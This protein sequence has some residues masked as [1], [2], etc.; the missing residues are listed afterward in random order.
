[1]VVPHRPP[2]RP[3][4]RHRRGDYCAV[5]AWAEL[6]PDCA[7]SQILLAVAEDGKPF[8]D[9][10]NQLW[11]GTV[12]A[13]DGASG[14]ETAPEPAVAQDGPE[15]RRFYRRALLAAGAAAVGGVGEAASA[16][17]VPSHG[18]RQAGILTPRQ[19]HV[20]LAAFDLGRA[21]TDR[22]RAARA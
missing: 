17:A 1:M 2:Q 16:P 15:H 4:A 12:D 18:P 3:A 19:S 6:A 22:P 9:E 21:R 14:P 13:A 20:R 8:D 7:K 11:V 10:L 5:F